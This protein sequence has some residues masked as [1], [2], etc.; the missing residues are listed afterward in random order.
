MGSYDVVLKIIDSDGCT[1]RYIEHI[2][3]EQ[4]RL[5]AD[6]SADSIDTDCPPLFIEFKNL[7][8]APNRKIKSYYWEFGDGT[9]S[10]EPTPSKLYLRAGRFTVKLFIEDDWGLYR[11]RSI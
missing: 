5:R 8:T 4:E 11:L 3:I 9:T 1:S 7:S 6:F 10:V 2:D